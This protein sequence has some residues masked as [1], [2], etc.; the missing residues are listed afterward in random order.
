MHIHSYTW[1]SSPSYF[2][3]QPR[4]F[5]L[6]TYRIHLKLSSSGLYFAF[7]HLILNFTLVFLTDNMQLYV[8]FMSFSQEKLTPAQKHEI[9]FH[10]KK[11]FLWPKPKCK[12]AYTGIKQCS[13]CNLLHL[14]NQHKLK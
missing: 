8:F 14:E 10:F 5:V 3:S 7:G 1:G 4:Y 11:E 9:Q 13:L 6:E 12:Y 2:F